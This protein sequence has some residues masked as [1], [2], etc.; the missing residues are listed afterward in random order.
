VD[1][2]RLTVSGAARRLG[3]APGTLRTWDRRYG[4][5]PTG[6]VRGMHRRYSG[7]DMARLELMQR[8]L[9]TGATPAEAARHARAA[10]LPGRATVASSPAPVGGGRL[11]RWPDPAAGIDVIASLGVP[12]P[13][14]R[15]AVPPDDPSP[16]AGPA[17]SG[18][19]LRMPGAGP[20]A[21]GLARAALALNPT[22]VRRIVDE[23][24]VRDGLAAAWEEVVRP[25]VDAVDARV[26][27]TGH[28]VE[29]ARLLGESATVVFHVRAYTAAPPPAMRPVLLA[30]MPGDDHG[31]P[32]AALGALLAQHRIAC[33]SLGPA[34]PAD[35]L[36]AAIR[37]VAPAVVVLWAE[38]PATADVAVVAALPV[39]R[40]RF[41]TYVAGPGW[42]DTV[43]PRGVDRPASV[44]E[45]ADRIGAAVAG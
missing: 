8:A 26:R 20:A 6:H 5:G 43:L 42:A 18:A 23:A 27:G 10:T 44:G 14:D 1:D 22:A 9:V 13:A 15:R 32:L 31:V 21:R 33:R 39:T 17:R 3:I 11:R 12:D 45:A 7:A 2:L 34:L 19:G 30:G 35:A 28:G 4:I 38:V 40:P 29:V 36:A 24:I 41:R 16:A 25:V 37:R